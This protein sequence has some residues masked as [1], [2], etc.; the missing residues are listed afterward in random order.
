LLTQLVGDEPFVVLLP[1]VIMVNREPVTRQL[2]TAY[3]KQGGSVVAIRE[4]EPQE[5]GRHGIVQVPHS[6][7]AAPAATIRVIGLVEKPSVANAPSRFG[8][9]GRYILEPVIWAAIEQT[10]PDTHGEVQLTDALN[11]LCQKHSVLGLRFE[12]QHYDAGDPFG[13]LK[14]HIELS[15]GDLLLGQPLREYLACLRT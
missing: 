8:V 10:D 3:N 12:G 14:A 6:T 9:F 7:V 13:Y 15:L 1:D 11:V 5:V 4:V 2:I